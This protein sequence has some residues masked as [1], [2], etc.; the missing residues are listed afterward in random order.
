VHVG[1]GTLQMQE[2]RVES[3]QPIGAHAEIFAHKP[4]AKGETAI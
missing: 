3:S 2:G 4:R 1:A